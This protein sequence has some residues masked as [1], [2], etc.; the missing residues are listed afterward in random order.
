MTEYV[1]KSYEKGF[2]IDQEKVGK[3]VAKSFIQPHQTNAERLK[4][5]YSQED[6]D[7][8][9]RLYAFKDNEMLGFLTAKILDETEDGIKRAN[10]TPPTILKKHYE[11]VSELLF[12]KAIDVLKSKNVKKILSTFGVRTVQDSKVAKKWGYNILSTKYFYSIDLKNID[13]SVSSD[14]VTDFDKTK[15]SDDVIE[16]HVEEFGVDEKRAKEILGEIEGIPENIYKRQLVLE[17]NGKVKAYAILVQNFLEPSISRVFAIQAKSEEFMKQM[18]SKISEISKEKNITKL[19]I[20]YTEESD[21]KLE[22]Y[23]PIKFEL[24]GTICQC[25]LDL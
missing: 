3:E 17:D 13:T 21:A 8:E 15:H 16:I 11:K 2:E 1:I 9:T 18:L 25:E 23:K 19:Q 7:P 14:K 10:L 4:E 22:K 12:N 5:L 6:F 20:A 24:S